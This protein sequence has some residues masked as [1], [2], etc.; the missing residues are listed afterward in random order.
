M[1]SGHKFAWIYWSVIKIVCS[2]IKDQRNFNNGL[3]TAWDSNSL[4]SIIPVLMLSHLVS[5]IIQWKFY[6]EQVVQLLWMFYDFPLVEWRGHWPIRLYGTSFKQ[7]KCLCLLWGVECVFISGCKWMGC[8]KKEDFYFY[9]E[10]IDILFDT[11]TKMRY[12]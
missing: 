10:Q 7:S 6:S 4:L 3:R 8:V 2:H 5:I 12:P 9:L 11:R 1:G